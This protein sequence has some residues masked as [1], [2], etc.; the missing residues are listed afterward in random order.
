[1]HTQYVQVKGRTRFPHCLQQAQ[2]RP[3]RKY[4][5]GTAPAALITVMAVAHAAFE[6]RTRRDGRR[7]RSIIAA[8]FSIAST[9]PATISVRRSL[10]LRSLQRRLSMASMY[11]P[12]GASGLSLARG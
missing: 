9:A 1:M 8:I 6:P 3:R 4:K 2:R 5:I 11:T 10:G 7:A 12:Q